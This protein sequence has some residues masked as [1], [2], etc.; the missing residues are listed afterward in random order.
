MKPNVMNNVNS[1]LGFHLYI[2]R[3][4]YYVNN[5]RD[6]ESIQLENL[7]DKYLALT[8]E[9]SQYVFI[10]FSITKEDDKVQKNSKLPAETLQFGVIK[11]ALV[12]LKNIFR[13]KKE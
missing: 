11:T 5:Y 10:D 7:I 3:H 9:Y 12:L 8:S 6:M 13:T 1:T 2:V 4:F